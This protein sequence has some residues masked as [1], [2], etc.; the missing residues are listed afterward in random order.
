MDFKFGILV[1]GKYGECRVTSAST[2][3]KQYLWASIL[4]GYFSEDGKLL[5]EPF[6]VFE[7]I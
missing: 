6:A 2:D 1:V 5:L 7:E 4:F 3:F